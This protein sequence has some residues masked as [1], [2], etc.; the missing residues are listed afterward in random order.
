MPIRHRIALI[1]LAVASALLSGC[2]RP[3]D[4]AGGAALAAETGCVACHGTNGR[5]T[6]PTFPNINGQHAGYMYEQL[7]KY[8]SGERVNII[9]NDQ[10]QQLS[11]AQME[12][13]AR[14]YAAQ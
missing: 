5:G 3:A 14:Y 10:A 7:K 11:N 12:L 1:G 8:R 13:L 4:I 6:G 9:M 2:G